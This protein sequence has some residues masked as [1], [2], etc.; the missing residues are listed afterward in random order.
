[1]FSK[2]PRSI[3][4]VA[5]V[6][7]VGGG[8]YG[9]STRLQ[10]WLMHRDRGGNSGT[11]DPAYFAGTV[12]C[13]VLLSS[14]EYEVHIIA[15]N[16]PHHVFVNKDSRSSALSSGHCP[17]TR[18][19]AARV[20]AAFAPRLLVHRSAPTCGGALRRHRPRRVSRAHRRG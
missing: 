16:W 17:I 2:I 4:V 5:T 14:S 13:V 6:I 12:D 20:G 3:A 18:R 9:S 15:V 1:M 19:P 8:A 10:Q 11:G 7:V